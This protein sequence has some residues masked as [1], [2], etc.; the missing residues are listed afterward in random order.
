MCSGLTAFSAIKKIQ[1]HPGIVGASD[2]LILGLGGLGFQGLG[3]CVPMLGGAALAADIDDSKLDEAHRLVPGCKTFNSMFPDSIKAIKAQSFDGTGIGAVI[4]F[5]GN[6]ATANFAE[7]VLRK[8]GKHVIC[9]LF[10]GMQHKPLL[11]FPLM[12]RCTEGSFVGSFEEAKE[13]M[14]L[15]RAGG[16]PTVPHHFQSIM[17]ASDSLVD[18]R[19]GKVLG[20]RIFIHDWPDAKI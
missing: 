9:G 8:G 18:L 19:E 16:V 7:G 3:F 15:L 4:D 20:R 13:M 12:A 11:M 10:G 5:V 17:T 2:V 6:E 1:R 14:G